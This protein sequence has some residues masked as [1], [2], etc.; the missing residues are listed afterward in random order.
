MITRTWSFRSIRLGVSTGDILLISVATSCHGFLVLTLES[1]VPLKQ[2]RLES[3][4]QKLWNQFRKLILKILFLWNP[5]QQQSLHKSG[6]LKEINPMGY[7]YIGI[8]FKELA[9]MIVQLVKFK[10][11]RA[12]QIGNSGKRCCCLESKIHSTGNLGFLCCFLEDKFLFHEL[13]FWTHLCI[14]G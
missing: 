3:Q 7:V 8:Y 12:N 13:C 5:Y 11:H 4:F 14:G 1:L 6:F 10:I 9:H 2:I